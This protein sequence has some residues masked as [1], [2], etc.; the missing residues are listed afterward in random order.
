[1]G[2]VGGWFLS[3]INIKLIISIKIA[4]RMTSYDIM[5]TESVFVNHSQFTE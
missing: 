3:S 4:K 5:Q 2:Q 1:M